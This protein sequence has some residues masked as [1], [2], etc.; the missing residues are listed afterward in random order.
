MRKSRVLIAAAGVAAIIPSQVSAEAASSVQPAQQANTQKSAELANL[1]DS[2]D[3]ADLAA[4][5]IAKMSRGIRDESYGRWDDFTDA[6]EEANLRR[7]LADT[8]R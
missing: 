3:Q 8:A 6:A 1:F 7:M 5:P 2:F 4:S